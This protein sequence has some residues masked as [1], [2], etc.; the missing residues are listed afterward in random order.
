MTNEC[1]F[2]LTDHSYVRQVLIPPSSIHDLNMAQHS[3]RNRPRPHHLQHLPLP[4]KT[5]NIPL[6]RPGIHHSDRADAA[7]V[8]PCPR[9]D[10]ARGQDVD[11]EE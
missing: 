6:H 4:T 8:L 7:L 10:H 11:G 2:H 5:R 3:H 1:K 9:A